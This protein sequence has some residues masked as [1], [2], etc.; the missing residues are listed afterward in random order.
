MERASKRAVPKDE[1]ELAAL[2]ARAVLRLNRTA[3]ER[4]ALRT[5]EEEKGLEVVVDTGPHVTADRA[6]GRA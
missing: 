2:L 4:A 1:I 5:Q 6:H 3:P